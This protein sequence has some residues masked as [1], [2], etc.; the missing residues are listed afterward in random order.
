MPALPAAIILM[1][2]CG[3]GKTLV[4]QTLAARTG[5]SFADADDFHS[6]QTREKMRSGTPL[7]DE[8]R[9]PWLDRLQAHLESQRQQG[10]AVV[11]A[12]SALKEVYRERLRAG[13]PR[14]VVA[15]VHLHGSPELIKARMSARQGHYMPVSLLESQL[16]TLETPLDALRVDIDATPEQIVGHIIAGLAL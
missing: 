7:T 11:L 4:G 2:V 8:D 15:F 3:S 6:E 5:A 14:T 13:Q 9:W 10:Q 12:C 16:S 1:G